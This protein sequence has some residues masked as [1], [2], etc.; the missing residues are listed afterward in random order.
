MR[1]QPNAAGDQE[2]G[3]EVGRGGGKK[4]E[5]QVALA[6][7]VKDDADQKEKRV[8]EPEAPTPG[9]AKVYGKKKNTVIQDQDKREKEEQ[10]KDGAE[11]HVLL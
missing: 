4:Q 7:K 11:D 3:N 1:L 8:A 2:R 9:P 5:N 6:P 10:E